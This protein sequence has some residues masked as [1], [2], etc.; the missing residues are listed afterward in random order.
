MNAEKSLK[1][2]AKPICF[3]VGPIC[4]WVIPWY[5]FWSMEGGQSK[6]TTTRHSSWRS[7]GS[8]NWSFPSCRP[9]LRVSV[10]LCHLRRCG[11]YWMG[12][13]CPADSCPRALPSLAH[14]TWSP[15]NKT[16]TSTV[17]SPWDSSMFVSTLGPFWLIQAIWILYSL[18][19]M[20]TKYF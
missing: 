6:T 15:M 3:L 7:Q 19:I 10:V 1:S 8:S 11:H 5:P 12:G 4:I 16:Q 14:C 9:V 2:L 18:C 13:V 20:Q 17:F